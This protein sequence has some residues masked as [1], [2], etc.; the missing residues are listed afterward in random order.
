M[1]IY[2]SICVLFSTISLFGQSDS[3][4]IS[5]WATYYY[6]PT[7]MHDEDGIDLLDKK[8]KK[9]GFKLDSC[10]WCNAAIEGTV[11]IKK[12]NRTYVF[13]YAG[14]S[15]KM[16]YDCRQCFKY[17][18]YE[19]YLNSGKVLWELSSGFGKGCKN[20]NLVPFIT[21]AV[22]TAIVPIGSVIYIP[23]AKGVKFIDADGRLVEHE[24]YF[25]AGD[26]GSK[27]KGNHID[28]FLGSSTENP[29]AFVKSNQDETFEAYLV[30]D[31]NLIVKYV[32]LH[33]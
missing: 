33:K 29:F 30:T 1:R 28:V 6:I 15:K 3:K 20:Y 19:D 4:K 23:K 5:L 2:L 13:N 12:E 27:I 21:I 10:D 26:V 18:N 22:D 17:K 7:L 32:N 9:T 8:E 16:Q 24:G 11:F 31:K 14:R 25:F